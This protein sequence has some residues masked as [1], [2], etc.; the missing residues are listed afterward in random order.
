MKKITY[1]ILLIIFSSIVF[2]FSN[3]TGT[4]S[5]H[6]SDVVTEKMLDVYSSITKKEISQD[7]KKGLILDMRLLIRK[8][9]H[10]TIYLVLGIL[11]YLFIDT[12]NLKHKILISILITFLFACSDEVHQ[13]FVDGRTGSI[14]DVGID[15]IGSSVGILLLNIKSIFTKKKEEA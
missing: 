13:L 2:F 8:T 10:F 4:D 11:T 3:S 14:I 6:T 1:C 7:R 12:Y 15:T 5:N 9:A